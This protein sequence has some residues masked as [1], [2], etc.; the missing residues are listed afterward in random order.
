MG[1]PRGRKNN[2][3]LLK[4]AEVAKAL[5]LCQ[6]HAALS[7]PDIVVAMAEEAKKGNVAAAK[8]ILDRVYPSMRQADDKG[9]GL[10]GITINITPLGAQEKEV[11]KAIDQGQGEAG[12]QS[13]EPAEGDQSFDHEGV[14]VIAF[15]G[16]QKG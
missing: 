8:L 4:E 16:G 2:A 1:R 15:D 5:K 12:E 6:G 14:K 9:P 3:T 10:A 7:A 11:G 13:D